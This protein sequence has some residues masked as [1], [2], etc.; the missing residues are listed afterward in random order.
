MI[1][2]KKKL[3]SKLKSIGE[4]QVRENLA[5]GL[6][7]GKN[8]VNLIKEWIIQRENDRES[9]S[10][11]EASRTASELL[12]ATKRQASAAESQASAAAKQAS[13]AVDAART[14]RTAKNVAIAAA[15]IG[16]IISMVNIIVLYLL[17]N[18]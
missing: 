8:K 6:Y 9:E 10:R 13:S 7:S 5:Q 14:A 16:A 4:Q 2:D 3:F 17:K 12:A 18:P 1:P 11:I 15:I